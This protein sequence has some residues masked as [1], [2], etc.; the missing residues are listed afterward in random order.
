MHYLEKY[1]QLI[2]RMNF[3]IRAEVLLAEMIMEE[4]HPEDIEIATN[5]VFSRNVH[6]DI[7]KVE[8]TEYV[9]TR[10]K[11]LRFVLNRD[12]IYDLLPEDLFHQPIDNNTNPDLTKMM[13]D[14]KVQQQREIAA[15]KFFLP[16]EQEF[17]RSRIRL[18]MEERKFM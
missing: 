2:N 12:G 1:K 3:D 15:R 8:D 7:E 6:F 18:E 5:S 9:T 16:Y 13:Q 11:R 10:K 14:M 4:V 17:F